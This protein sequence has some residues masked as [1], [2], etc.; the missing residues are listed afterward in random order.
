METII[1]TKNSGVKNLKPVKLLQRE[2]NKKLEEESKLL[3]KLVKVFLNES[4][5]N[6]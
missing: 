5:K 2:L 6:Y 1:I 4:V 3:K